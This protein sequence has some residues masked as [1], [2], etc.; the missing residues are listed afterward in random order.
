MARLRSGKAGILA[1]LAVLPKLAALFDEAWDAL[2]DG[3][4]SKEEVDRI[5]AD[6]WALVAAAKKA[7]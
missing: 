5:G 1:W 7:A 2:D 6:F 4:L 3:E